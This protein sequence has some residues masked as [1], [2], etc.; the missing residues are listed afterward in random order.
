ME[1]GMKAVIETGM[2]TGMETGRKINGTRSGKK[3]NG[4]GRNDESEGK[5]MRH[6]LNK[7]KNR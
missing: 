2:E 5:L 4:D 1:T 7:N 3:M 6:G